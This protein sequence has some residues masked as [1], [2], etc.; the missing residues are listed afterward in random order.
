MRMTG[1]S[2]SGPLI[3]QRIVRA[4]NLLDR[5][6]GA[7]G[8]FERRCSVVSTMITV[9][10][11]HAAEIV[12]LQPKSLS[13]FE[14]KIITTIWGPSRPA[15]AKEIVF[16][17]LCAGH[18]IAHT[19]II[20]YQRAIWLA[21]LCCTR[22]PSLVL[23]QA[24]WEKNPSLQ[25]AGPF[26]RALQILHNWGLTP[27][28][29]WWEW[30]APGVA[31]TLSLIGDKAE[32]KH[33]V[34]EQ[35][36][37]QLI[38]QL[39]QRR[40][41]QFTGMHYTTNR[42]LVPQSIL[43]FTSVLER[44]LLRTILAGGVWTALRAHQRGM[45]PSSD[46]PFC[47]KAAEIEQH[48]FWSCE[49][50]QTIRDSHTPS[51]EHLAQQFP[52]L[53]R[54][55][56]WPPC[57]LTCG[58]APDISLPVNRQER[59]TSLEFFQAI[60]AMYVAILAAR[61]IR[62]EQARMLFPSARHVRQTG[63]PYQQLTGPVPRTE[64]LATLTL[65]KPTAK[66]WPWELP[67]LVDLLSW[68][69]QLVW[70]DEPGTV[71]FIELAL[72]F[73]ETSQRTLPTAPQAKY[74]GTTL[75]LQERARVLRLAVCTMQ[76]L[77]TRGALH[78]AKVITRANSLVPLGG[79]Q[80]SGLSRRPYFVSRQAMVGHIA[81]LSQYCEETWALR[82][83]SR[84]NKA[85]S[86]VYRH[87][88]SPAEVEE[89]RIQRALMGA[90][91]TGLMPSSSDTAKGG[92]GGLSRQI[93]SPSLVRAKPR[94]HLTRPPG[95]ASSQLRRRRKHVWQRR[96]HIHAHGLSTYATHTSARRASHASA[97]A[98][99][100][101]RAVPSD[102]TGQDMWT[103]YPCQS[104]A[105]S[106]DCRP[107]PDAPE[108]KGGSETAV[109]EGT[110]KYTRRRASGQPRRTR[111]QL[112]GCAPPAAPHAHTWSMRAPRTYQPHRPPQNDGDPSHHAPPPPPPR[113]PAR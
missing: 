10:G 28:Q 91:N 13:S 5:V 79:P 11:L 105:A 92:G 54:T 45:R 32:V 108:C 12:P 41:R 22:G 44:S 72:H 96:H 56:H 57:L 55:A 64:N 80:Q 84:Q 52:G 68:A 16:C 7:Q 90:L 17:L 2:S 113:G 34:R 62:D 73:E 26:G 78:P 21:K 27:A 103:G 74:R 60:H 112:S 19:L 47:G 110:T 59:N 36:R 9:T 67:F 82:T 48:I 3:L 70:A 77:V 100:G 101:T 71:T 39:I 14:T 76:K 24:I 6:H 93:S 33:H 111:D 97:C 107:A 87:G 8:H 15:R 88:R 53:E 37:A 40:P 65:A 61:K 94:R 20:P 58:L 51:I 23:A 50:W 89:A 66:T 98:N 25:F 106:M 1:D 99:Q 30:T 31:Q 104:R 81:K 83:H 63:Y 18:R 29:G 95:N 86:Y 4:S 85:R 75:P 38:A 35:L 46:C 42:R 109:P 43:S 102:I 49:A 69:R